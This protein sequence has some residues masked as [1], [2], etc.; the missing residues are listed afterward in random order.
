[1]NAT[2]RKFN[3]ILA[4]MGILVALS[5]CSSNELVPSNISFSALLL[6]IMSGVILLNI[7]KP[8]KDNKEE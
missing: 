7:G 6:V 2:I 5:M 8:D 3:I 1:M 4:T